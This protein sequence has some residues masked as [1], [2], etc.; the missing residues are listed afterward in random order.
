MIFCMYSAILHLAPGE[1]YQPQPA[2][3]G[4]NPYLDLDYSGYPKTSSNDQ[5]FNN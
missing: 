4:D 1:C 3:S 5:L 2:A